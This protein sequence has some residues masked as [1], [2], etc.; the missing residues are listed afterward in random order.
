MEKEKTVFFI[1][2]GIAMLIYILPSIF[3][4]YLIYKDQK[5][6]GIPSSGKA[7]FDE[8]QKLL[9]SQ[10]SYHALLFLCGF[11]FVWAVIHH[12]GIFSWTTKITEIVFCALMLTFTIRQIECSLRDVMIGW[13]QNSGDIAAQLIC[14]F[15]FGF[16]FIILGA[17]KETS[18]MIV[19]MIAALS[20]WVQFGVLCYAK[21]RRNK[22]ETLSQS[23]N[24]DEEV[25]AP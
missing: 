15:C 20:C 21:H 2:I 1:G 10:A 5:E 13:N 7:L 6:Q 8:R 17:E 4:V 18:V 14:M 9:R 25:D 23:D 24:S 11:L 12:L 22:A 19:C 16:V 3:A